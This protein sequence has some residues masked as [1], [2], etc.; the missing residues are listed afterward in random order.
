[1][2]KD[3]VTFAFLSLLDHWLMESQLLYQEERPMGWRTMVTGQQSEGRESTS[4]LTQDGSWSW[5]LGTKLEKMEIQ[6]SEAEKEVGWDLRIPH[7]Q[8]V[9]EET[10]LQ[11]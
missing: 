1:M 2:L 11:G 8:W 10:G 6:G 3:I 7:I 5:E 4:T 9:D